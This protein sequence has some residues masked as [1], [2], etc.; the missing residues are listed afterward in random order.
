MNNKNYIDNLFAGYEEN[1]SLLDFKEELNSNLEERIAHLQRG[2]MTPEAAF[3]KVT[4]E[5]GDISVL[6][7]EISLKKKQEVLADMY[8]KT[9][10]YIGTKRMMAYI[11]CAGVFLFGVIT[12]SLSWLYLD[13]P[14]A[15]IGTMLPFSLLPAAIVVFLGLTQETARYR[16]MEWKR[17][18][19]YAVAAVVFLFGLFIF[20]LTF[21]VR[22][23]GLPAAI[24]TLI[25]FCLPS[26]LVLAFLILTEKDRSK[27][28]VLE[29]QKEWSKQYEERFTDPTVAT[30]YGLLCGALWIFSAAFFLILGFL[31]GFRW[32]WIIFIF[33]IG[34]QL[35]L[36]YRFSTQR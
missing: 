8:M 31:I 27:P 9:R 29:Q 25:P 21:F 3:Y 6:A 11:L 35:L 12:A 23:A 4:S 24:A 19:L 17:A 2:G 1:S 15:G 5:L 22:D 33:S 26:A 32:A 36:E 30:R 18:L 13:L 34:F 14:I 20:L 7:D 16:P 28:W 10:S